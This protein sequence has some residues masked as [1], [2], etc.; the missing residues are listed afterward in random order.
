MVADYRVLGIAA[1]TGRIGYA[2]LNNEALVDWGLSKKASRSP[3]LA[4]RQTRRWIE[5]HRPEVI[6]IEL[7]NSRSRKRG[8]TPLL[9]AAVSQ[10]AADASVL[11]ASVERIQNYPNKY[12]EARALARRFPDLSSNVP[13]QPP[14]W[15]PEPRKLIYFEALALTL[16]VQTSTP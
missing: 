4:A 6:V 1:G 11:T 10:A 5:L 15:L 9:I 3:E 14:I 2:L 13:C 8:R 7:L 12:E 16:S